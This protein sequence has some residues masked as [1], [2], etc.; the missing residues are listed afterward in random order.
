MAEKKN[1]IPDPTR[2]VT[3]RRLYKVPTYLPLFSGPS[4][5][6]IPTITAPSRISPATTVLPGPATDGG[7]VKSVPTLGEKALGNFTGA[8]LTDPMTR[9]K[10]IIKNNLV[11]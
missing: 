8:K 9:G 11:D 6:R 2:L 1:Q 3:P 4:I 10:A 7:F 5:P